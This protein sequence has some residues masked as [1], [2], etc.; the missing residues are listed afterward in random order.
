MNPVR[1]EGS[2][3][4]GAPKGWDHDKN[5]KCG[6]LP[7]QISETDHGMR[8]YTSVWKFTDEERAAVLRGENLV[9]TCWSAQVPIMLSVHS[10]DGPTVDLSQ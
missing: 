3:P 7:V 9:I 2:T 8:M 5:G 4:F 6:A 10:V 1:F